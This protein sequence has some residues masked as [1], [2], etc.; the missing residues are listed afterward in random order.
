LWRR[1]R[2]L[3]VRREFSPNCS[4]PSSQPT[5]TSAVISVLILQPTGAMVHACAQNICR[6]R[7]LQV[8]GSYRSRF[9]CRR[10]SATALR[11]SLRFAY[12]VEICGEDGS[13]YSLSWKA[14]ASVCFK[15]PVASCSSRVRAVSSSLQFLASRYK[16]SSEPPPPI[17]S[18]ATPTMSNSF[19]VLSFATWQYAV[20]TAVRLCRCSS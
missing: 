4:N 2:W 1:R 10:S 20:R 13:G 15:M 18:T 9:F 5:P 17:W 6:W 7:V 14:L 11:R 16:R 19:G 8:T 12:C 3:E